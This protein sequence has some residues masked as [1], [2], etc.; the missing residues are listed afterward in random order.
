[1]VVFRDWNHLRQIADFDIGS[2]NL[3]TKQQTD[4]TVRKVTLQTLDQDKRRVI[5]ITD[6]E[7][8]FVFR[9]VLQAVAAEA[10][11]HLRVGAL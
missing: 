3:R 1:M 6:S 7:N 4:V 8:D 10:L 5:A 9:I 2:E 11:I